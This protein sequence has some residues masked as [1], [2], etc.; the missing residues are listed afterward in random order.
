MLAFVVRGVVLLGVLSWYSATVW[1]M[2][3]GYFKDQFRTYLQEE[4]RKHPRMRS[5]VENVGAVDKESA[6]RVLPTE[7]SHVEIY[8]FDAVC[9]ADTADI[10]P[11]AAA[12]EKAATA[13]EEVT[14]GSSE[15]AAA[16]A[17]A[18]STDKNAFPKSATR[19]ALESRKLPGGSGV[20][21]EERRSAAINQDGDYAEEEAIESSESAPRPAKP[22]RL[23]NERKSAVSAGFSREK[24]A[25]RR[26]NTVFLTDL[27]FARV[28]RTSG[29]GHNDFSEFEDDDEESRER[30]TEGIPVS[31][32]PFKPKADIGGLDKVTAEE[33]CPLTL[34][35]EASCGET[36]VWP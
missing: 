6:R 26:V 12:S 9:P 30:P 22:R 28:R 20:H 8:G 34:E 21:D 14:G 1:R 5:D 16:A 35:D 4:Y 13:A 17:A 36:T 31:E 29:D 3:D 11:R 27:D 32:L 33:F 19:S 2:I 7:A 23:H 24:R 25:K 15:N 18:G 10:C